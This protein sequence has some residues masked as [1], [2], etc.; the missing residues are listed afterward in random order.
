MGEI[1]RLRG[2]VDRLLK[3]RSAVCRL[4]AEMN[5]ADSLAELLQLALP[6]AL[7]L[8][9]ANAGLIYLLPMDGSHEGTIDSIGISP[10][11]T[12]DGEGL[13]DWWICRAGQN[14]SPTAIFT[15][16]ELPD[17]ASLL[18]G[19]A[20][21]SLL[22][23]SIS[24]AHR[25]IGVIGFERPESAA[26]SYSIAEAELLGCIAGQLATA[27]QN[28]RLRAYDTSAL[29]LAVQEERNR[30]AREIHDGVSQNMALLILKMEIIS[31]LT[32]RD[33]QRVKAELTKTQSI[34]EASVY[35]LRRSIY[36]LRSP[37]IAGL[38]LI[39]ALQRL[40]KEF[41][42]Q[43]NIE[44][45]LRLPAT[46]TLPPQPLSAAFSVVQE[47]LDVVSS[48]RSASRVAV[49]I[50]LASDHL[51]VRVTDNGQLPL[52]PPLD[53]EDA[54]P[55]WLARLKDRVRPLGG[56]VAVTHEPPETLVGVTI[57]L[58]Q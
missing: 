6:R 7:Q 35:Q 25:L 2:E 57:P 26:G 16:P 37:D 24:V 51:S 15:A 38:G 39:P 22:L 21:T 14:P 31:R 54:G 13:L 20:A 56:T 49:H 10:T 4:S 52:L 5:Q 48:A 42:E 32:D 18:R 45:D 19:E 8:L 41:T 58:R 47:R 28:L 23:A 29:E 46:L 50:R 43:T 11:A 12:A 55:P 17:V 3:E 30:I 36:T 27:L 33:P 9:T 34:I 40:A 53:E 1:E 44:V